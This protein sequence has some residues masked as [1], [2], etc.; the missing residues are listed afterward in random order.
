M[1]PKGC[2]F[3]IRMPPKKMLMT[4]LERLSLGRAK[5]SCSCEE[6][7]MPRAG[8]KLGKT[9]HLIVQDKV[10]EVNALALTQRGL[11]CFLVRNALRS[12]FLIFRR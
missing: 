4:K 10:A 9:S 2:C 7:K 1:L 12:L 11:K 6:V 5:T 3:Q 8:K